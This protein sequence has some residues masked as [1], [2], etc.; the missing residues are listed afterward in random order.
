[1]SHFKHIFITRHGHAN[2]DA[3]SDFERTL[4]SKGI[5]AVS[6]TATFI[7]QQCTKSEIVPQLCISSA[8]VRTKQTA[9]IICN[10][11]KVDKPKS[12]QELYS[13]TVSRWLEVISRENLKTIIIVGHNPTLS[14]MLNNLCG[15]QIHMQPANCAFITLKLNPDGLV[16]PATLN[17]LYQNE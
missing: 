11:I 10:T 12:Y 5:Q 3:S 9:E 15:Y 13:S 2:F 1:M 17:E 16:Y 6:D 14:Q 7:Q 8:A 4:T